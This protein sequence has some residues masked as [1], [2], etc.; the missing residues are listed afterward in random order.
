MATQIDE[1]FTAVLQIAHGALVVLEER[2]QPCVLDLLARRRPAA[3]DEV[4]HLRIAVELD[5]VLDVIDGEPP[6]RQALGS[7]N[8]CTDGFCGLGELAATR[9]TWPTRHAFPGMF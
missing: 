6:Q 8:T 3:R 9:P 2:R 1:V 7:R 5:E 4:H